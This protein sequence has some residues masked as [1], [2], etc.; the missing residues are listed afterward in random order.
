MEVTAAVFAILGKMSADVVCKTL[1]FTLK[2]QVLG[3][4]GR[5]FLVT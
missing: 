5:R 3:F 2:V 1:N 4:V